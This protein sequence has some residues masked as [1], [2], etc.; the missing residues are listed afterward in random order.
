MYL[1]RVTTRCACVVSAYFMV[2]RTWSARRLGLSHTGP[3]A[4]PSWVL[5]VEVPRWSGGISHSQLRLHIAFLFVARITAAQVHCL[6]G[7]SVAIKIKPTAI[8]RAVKH[9]IPELDLRQIASNCLHFQRKRIH[10]YFACQSHCDLRQLSTIWLTTFPGTPNGPAPTAA[11]H[12][13]RFGCRLCCHCLNATIV[14]TSWS[15]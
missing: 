8:L 10:T 9:S 2:I 15:P 4:P 3:H 1:H 14:G 5:R 6:A 12:S 13:N 7:Q 11:C